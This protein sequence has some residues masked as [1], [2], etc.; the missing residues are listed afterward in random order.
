MKDKMTKMDMAKI[1]VTALYNLKALVTEDQ[2]VAWKHAKKMARSKKEDLESM[3]NQA[4]AILSVKKIYYAYDYQPG[5]LY[6]MA[7]FYRVKLN[8]GNGEISIFWAKEKE[9]E[10]RIIAY[11]ECD[12]TGNNVYIRRDDGR[13]WLK[14]RRVIPEMVIREKRAYMNLRTGLLEVNKEAKK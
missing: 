12:R 7:I 6:S 13:L 3:C 5:P 2:R 8:T 14:I 9:I 1:I 10:G 4:K 11:T